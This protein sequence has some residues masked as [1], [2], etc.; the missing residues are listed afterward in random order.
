VLAAVGQLQFDVFAD[1]L[2]IEFNAPSE[3]LSAPYESIRFTDEES[4]ERL[5][6]IG[7]IRILARGDGRLVALF[8]SRYRLQRIENDEP[9]LMLEPIT[10]G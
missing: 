9:A 7:G 10:A 6:E 2:D 4:A 3:I 8:E 1:R 5:R